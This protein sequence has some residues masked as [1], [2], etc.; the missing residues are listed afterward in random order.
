M[1]VESNDIFKY[2]PNEVQAGDVD[3]QSA[4]TDHTNGGKVS[5]FAYAP[6][7]LVEQGTAANIDGA[8]PA[9][10]AVNGSNTTDGITHIS[11][12]NYA[13][14]PYI[15]YTVPADINTGGAFVDLL[16]GTLNSTT[17]NVISSGT[18]G[19]VTGN[20]SG[21][22]GEY[23]TAVLHGNTVNADLTKQEVDGTVGFLFKHA[24]AKLGGGESN[25][26]GFLVKLDIDNGG[27]AS[28]GARETF[29]IG[30]SGSDNAWRT[31]VT[32]DNITITND[33]DNSGDINGS[34]VGIGGTHRLNL[35]TGQ[36]SEVTAGG[37]YTQTIAVTGANAVLNS[38]I[39]EKYDGSS[40]W[41]THL[42]SATNYFSYTN[43]ANINNDHPGVFETPINIYNSNTQSPIILIPGCTPKFK[44]TV[45]YIVRTYDA[46][47][48]ASY[49]EVRQKITK[50]VTFGSAI[51][52]NKY[53]T[54]VMHLG[55]TG[56]KFTAGVTNWNDED[57]DGTPDSTP[58][59]TVHLPLN[60]E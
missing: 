1:F 30:S 46:N 26:L 39:A 8:N 49:S 52:L 32:I 15:T 40:T 60:V 10:G 22:A 51:Q 3:K 18:N 44:I 17:Q 19:G 4:T 14:D 41:L 48:S 42:G 43:T 57:G 11:G 56:I 31:I 33:L 36:W 50:T 20:S 34:E 16:W 5:F 47:L 59:E 58:T 12:N 9:T 35:A 27:T 21:T 37:V 24:L 25:S 29:D 13:G 54:L 23:A 6:Y 7:V 28:G 2:W 55:L 38:K 53:Y 45:D